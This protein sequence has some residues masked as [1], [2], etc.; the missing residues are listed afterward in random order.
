MGDTLTVIVAIFIAIILFLGVPLLLTA[1]KSDNI[2]QLAVQTATSEYVDEIRTIGKMTLDDHEKYLSTIT[3]TGN[4]FE[5]EI[6]IQQ[7]DENPGKKT[8]QAE[9]VKIGENLY[10]NK[11][12]TQ[13]M[14]ELNNSGRIILKEGDIVSVTVKNTNK[15]ISQ[16]L[17][18][19]F[20]KVSGNEAYQILA[21]QAG[22]VAV[23][24][25]AYGK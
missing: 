5:V 14:D 7:L 22:V 2:S 9:T 19:M 12:T 1:D 3:A 23:N 16:L 21:S 6:L 18:N 11:Y 8:T 10:Y 25:T 20:Y 15:T 17:K 13:V 4:S 24:G